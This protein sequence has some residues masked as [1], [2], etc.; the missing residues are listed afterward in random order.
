MGQFS[1][2]FTPEYAAVDVAPPPVLEGLWSCPRCGVTQ[3]PNE[4][5]TVQI[6]EPGRNV[7]VEYHGRVRPT[8][9]K[10][11]VGHQWVEYSCLVCGN[12]W[13][14]PLE[15]PTLAGYASSM[16][17]PYP[18]LERVEAERAGLLPERDAC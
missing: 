2:L 18:I 9:L 7:R 10:N 5:K 12:T 11:V 15:V 6:E 17:S 3:D 1:S 4:V 16:T 8:T 13:G 14:A